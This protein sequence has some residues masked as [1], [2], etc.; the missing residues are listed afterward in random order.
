MPSKDQYRGMEVAIQAGHLKG[1]HG[2][3]K[4]T[5]EEDGVVVVDVQT[6]TRVENSL[7]A[8]KVRDVKELR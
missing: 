3:V 4:G 7:I 1:H 2:V 6:T 8:F 5:R